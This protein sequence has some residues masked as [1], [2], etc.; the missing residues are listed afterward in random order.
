VADQNVSM[1]EGKAF[2]CQV[3]AGRHAGRAPRPTVP[4][5]TFPDRRPI[6]DTPDS[7]QP[8]GEFTHGH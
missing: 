5:S 3:E 1:H 7:A 6:P 8:E 2:T 4:F